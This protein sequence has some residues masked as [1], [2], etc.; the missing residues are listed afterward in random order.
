[1]NADANT[2][3]AGDEHFLLSCSRLVCHKHH[4]SV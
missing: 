1:L 2:V 3:A 4:T